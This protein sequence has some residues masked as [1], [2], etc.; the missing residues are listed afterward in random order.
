[1]NSEV[2]SIRLS[3]DQKIGTLIQDPKFPGPIAEIKI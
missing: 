1:M 2:E 3:M